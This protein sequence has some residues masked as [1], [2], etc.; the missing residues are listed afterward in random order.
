MKNLILIAGVILTVISGAVEI[1]PDLGVPE[2][3][4]LHNGAVFRDRKLIFPAAGSF[5]SLSGTQDLDFSRGG[6]L[7]MVVRMTDFVKDPEKFRFFAEKKDS[8]LLGVTNGR[9]NF[10]LCNQGKWNIALMGGTPPHNANF[11]HLAAVVRRVDDPE[12]G[13]FG[14]HLTLYQNGEKILTKFEP[15]RTYRADRSSEIII[16][17][18]DVKTGF[19]GEVVSFSF[20]DKELSPNAINAAAK[21]SRLVKINPPA[22]IVKLSPHL[23]NR[24][25]K[26]IAAYPAG[27]AGFTA[28]GLYNAACSGAPGGIVERAAKVMERFGGR[29]SIKNFNAAQ[30]GFALLANSQ[31]GVLMLI[32]ARSGGAFPV[33]DI[34]D[35][36]IDSGI[37]GQRSNSWQIYYDMEG[38]RSQLLTDYSSGMQTYGELLGVKN[39]VFSFRITWKHPVATAVSYGRFSDA[40]LEMDFA[41]EAGN[42]NVRMRECQFPNWRFKKKSG[43]DLLITPRFSGVLVADPIENYNYATYYPRAE[44][45]MQFHAYTGSRNDGVYAAMEDP[46]ATCRFNGIFGKNDELNIF[47]RTP[48]A[49]QPEGCVSKFELNGNT[50]VT[51]YTGQWFEAGQIYKKFVSE[52]AAWWI[53]EL[54]R[55]SSPQWF[56]DNAIWILA[57]VFPER[58][59]NTL[60]YLRE[61]FEQSF[62]VHLVGTTTQRLWPHFDRTSEIGKKRLGNL[63]RAGLRVLPYCDARL[64]SKKQLDGSM[65]WKNEQLQWAIKNEKGQLLTETH[66]VPCLILCPRNPAWQQEYLRI[67]AGIAQNGFDAI[68]HDQLPCGHPAMCFADNHGHLPNDPSFWI[69]NGYAAMFKKINAH[70]DRE[71]P[72]M[73]HTGED[74]SEPYL[75][76]IDGFTTWRWIQENQI[77]LFQSVYSGRIQFTGKIYNHQC[78]GEWESN[79]AKAASQVVNGEQLGWIT[80]EDLEAATPFRKY[81]KTL[82]FVRKA[83][84]EYFNAGDMTAPLKFIRTPETVTLNWGNT[85]K[86]RDA[87]QVALPVIL[88]S[89]WQLPDGR[90]MVLFINTTDEVQLAEAEIPYKYK[91][92][93]IC[94]QDSA[95][96]LAVKQAPALKI[97]PYGVEVWLIAEKDNQ[98]EAD[99]IAAALHRTSKFDEGKTL[100]IKPVFT[101]KVP[102]SFKVDSG[103]LVKIGNAAKYTNTFRRYFANGA[104]KD[105]VLIVYNGSTLQF[106]GMVFPENTKHLEVVAAYDASEAGGE[107]E[108]FIDGKSAGKGKLRTPGKYLKF[109]MVEIQL[110]QSLSGKHNVEFRFSGKSCRLKGFIAR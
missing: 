34:Y 82:S 52:K 39:G 1:T 97:P 96:A 26:L 65:Q 81:F 36:A 16:S 5:A 3:V 64:Y 86:T 21:S 80:L 29:F 43:K 15:V 49:R 13:K 38:K 73:A 41:A 19:S 28:R 59:Q 14:F 109:Q 72:G 33:V 108:L 35:P 22:G 7:M 94:R 102:K 90:R 11:V 99:M 2:Q 18:R 77:P 20:T 66:N 70:L 106:T 110:S 30:K 92:F 53:K 51:S 101:R 50:R 24:L 40:G 46:Q 67:C 88:H 55:K 47:W 95:K 87:F 74:G 60:L 56:R 61:Y 4:K 9:Y 84:L 98:A 100:Q 93:Y 69:Q 76:M 42:L 27:I 37:L 91:N 17:S 58:N 78:P 10:S 12:Q 63:Q 6:T 23:H 54:P 32:T 107:F 45:T 62:G 103:K 105:T 85:S 89:T 79:F 104:D 71:Y 31:G 8:F 68:Y 57:G 48:V 25:Q 75:Q 44:I 83:L